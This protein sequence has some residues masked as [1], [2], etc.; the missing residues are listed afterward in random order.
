MMH[1]FRESFR[2]RDAEKLIENINENGERVIASRRSSPRS[3]IAESALRRELAEDISSLLNTIN[4]ASIENLS[5]YEHVRESIL[6]FGVADLAS[7]TS[8]SIAARS[9]TSELRTL[10]ENYEA[11]LVPGTIMVKPEAVADD[12]SG[13]I[14]FHVNAEM[15]STPVDVA[16]EFVAE[17]EVDSGQVKVLKL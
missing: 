17:V 4:L 2:Q 6:N 13:R 10:L 5:A 7:V 14:R 12:A 3:A 8:G 15:Y 11:R 1:A 9:I 16:V